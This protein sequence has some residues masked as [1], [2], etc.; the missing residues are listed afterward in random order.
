MCTDLSPFE[1]FSTGDTLVFSFL[2]TKISSYVHLVKLL[3]HRFLNL[4]C[5]LPPLFGDFVNIVHGPPLLIGKLDV[6]LHF[7]ENLR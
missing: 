4:S 2:Q 6:L 1:C 7:D 3:M 5:Y